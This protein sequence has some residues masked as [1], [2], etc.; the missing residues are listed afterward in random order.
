MALLYSGSVVMSMAAK[1]IKGH[2]D[3]QF[4]GCH[5]APCCCSRA[6][7][8]W[9][10]GCLVMPPGVMVTSWI[11]LLLETM[12]GAIVL[13]QLEPELISLVH[14]NIKGHRGVWSLDYNLWF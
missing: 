5:F 3:A 6:M 12:S 13:P 2:A 14:G 1:T 8:T 7:L 10:Y 11:R 4:L 9:G